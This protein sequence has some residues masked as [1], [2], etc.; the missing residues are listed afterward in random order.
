MPD[1]T[2]DLESAET[3]TAETGQA[4][5]ADADYI[6]KLRREAAAHRLAARKAEQERDALKAERLTELERATARVKDL[7]TQLS[8]REMERRVTALTLLLGEARAQYPRLLAREV[9][10]ASLELEPD[11][12]IR[13]GEALVK[14]L[15]TQYPALFGAGT[16][17]AGA[18]RTGAAPVA[19]MTDLI[20]RRAGRA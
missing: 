16:A 13:N 4:P 17:D 5:A 6:T 12:T 20:R 9:D 14:R 15:R 3:D 7:E 1:A 11:G 19:S 10:T 18:G 8:A 2:A